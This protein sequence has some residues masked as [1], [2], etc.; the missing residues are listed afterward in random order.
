MTQTNHNRRKIDRRQPNFDEIRVLV[1]HLRSENRNISTL[2]LLKDDISD[3]TQNIA[4]SE[5]T[6]YDS[7]AI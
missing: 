7:P 5:R 2:G 1:V 6:P 3:S 4:G